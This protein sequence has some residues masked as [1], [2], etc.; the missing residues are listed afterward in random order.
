MTKALFAVVFVVSGVMLVGCA[1]DERDDGDDGEVGTDE[2]AAR[3]AGDLT[4]RL[5][6]AAE[7]SKRTPDFYMLKAAELADEKCRPPR[8]F[9]GPYAGVPVGVTITVENGAIRFVGIASPQNGIGLGNCVLSTL[10]GQ[11]APKHFGFT[12]TATFVIGAPLKRK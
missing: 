3:H 11:Q 1:A 7:A 10:T 8:D 12:R 6:A 4:R 9:V 2:A 5:L